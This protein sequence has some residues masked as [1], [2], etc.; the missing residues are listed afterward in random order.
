MPQYSVL[1]EGAGCERLHKANLRLMMFLLFVVVIEPTEYGLAYEEHHKQRDEDQRETVITQKAFHAAFFF[2]ARIVH[3]RFLLRSLGEFEGSGCHLRRQTLGPF[4]V[5]RPDQCRRAGS[6]GFSC[7]DDESPGAGSC[8]GLNKLAFLW[9][10]AFFE[11]QPAG[12]AQRFAQA[13][14]K[15]SWKG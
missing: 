11:V 4:G 5:I 7:L 15:V 13:R 12:I 3:T 6:C 2:L 14:R 10:Q 8:V 1:A 9:Q